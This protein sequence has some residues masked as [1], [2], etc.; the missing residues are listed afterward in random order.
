MWLCCSHATKS[1]VVFFCCCFLLLLVFMCGGEGYTSDMLAML[2][3]SGNLL[4]INCSFPGST[5]SSGK[6][7]RRLVKLAKWSYVYRARAPDDI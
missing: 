2:R 3:M 7:S 5:H 6:S 4:I 1:V